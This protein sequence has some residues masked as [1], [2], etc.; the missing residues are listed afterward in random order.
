MNRLSDLERELDAF[1]A[2]GVERAPDHVVDAAIRDVARTDQELV[3]RPRWRGTSMIKLAGLAAAAAIA[4]LVGALLLTR[5]P[6][7]GVGGPPPGTGQPSPSASVTPT[8]TGTARPSATAAPTPF[9]A[10]N[11]PTVGSLEDERDFPAGATEWYVA[12]DGTLWI[13]GGGPGTVITIDTATGEQERIGSGAHVQT[14]AVAEGSVW[15]PRIGSVIERIDIA[16][17][18][19]VDRIETP[20]FHPY[21]IAINGNDLWLTGY[22]DE[23]PSSEGVMVID[24][25]TKVVKATISRPSAGTTGIAIGGGL[26]WVVENG[27]G[28]LLRIDATTYEVVGTTDVGASPL[29]VVYAF[30]SAW[31]AARRSN[32]V[33]R[34]GTDGELIEQIVLPVGD[35]TAGGLRGAYGI[36]VT[37]D[38]VWAV[39]APETGCE[40]DPNSANVVRIDPGTNE[41]TG[42]VPVR[43]AYGVAAGDDGDLWVLGERLSRVRIDR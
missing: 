24:A 27:T 4:V 43:C 17:R 16:S 7:T 19:I 31:V 9:L 22:S 6:T 42:R 40:S 3:W 11:V 23:D 21:A 12:S 5:T 8:G 13:P 38:A 14:V 18:E 29:M 20:D 33:F 2:A 26:A 41:V 30:D 10:A 39:G 37:S 32:A 28:R 36:T 1:L 35:S 15:F 25:T 34:V